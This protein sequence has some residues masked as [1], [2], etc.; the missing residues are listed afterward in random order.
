MEVVLENA[1]WKAK[2]AELIGEIEKELIVQALKRYD[3]N[4]TAAMESLGISRRTFY[5]KLKEYRIIE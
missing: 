2:L 4:R 3:N 1:L 5:K